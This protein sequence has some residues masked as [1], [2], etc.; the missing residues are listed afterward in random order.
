MSMAAIAPRRRMVLALVCSVAMISAC[1]PSI[2]IGPGATAIATEEASIERTATATPVKT[3]VPTPTKK[4]APTKVPPTPGPT[5]PPST[6][7]QCT[8]K[9]KGLNIRRGPGTNFPVVTAVRSG[10]ALAASGKNDKGDWLAVKTA[11][12]KDGWAATKYLNCNPA[13]DALPVKPGP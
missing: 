6:T 2:S 1:R 3:K 10:A 11:N 8:I 13:P 7:I 9:T 5:Q 4:P 12:G